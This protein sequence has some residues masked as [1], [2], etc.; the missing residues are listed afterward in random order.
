M[1]GEIGILYQGGNQVGGFLDWEIAV[2]VRDAATYCKAIADKFWLIMPS[3]DKSCKATFYKRV[4]GTLTTV[5]T[6]DVDVSLG[7][8][9]LNTVIPFPLEMSWVG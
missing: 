4:K 6:V 3:N 9:P 5:N 1:N 7:E 8:H 2:S